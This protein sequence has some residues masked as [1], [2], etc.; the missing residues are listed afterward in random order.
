M[1]SSLYASINSVFESKADLPC[2]RTASTTWT[3]SQ[4]RGLTRCTAGALRQLG[5]QRGDRVLAQGGKCPQSLALY[6][7]CLQLGVIYVPLNPA[8][9]Q[10]EIDYFIND[11]EP[12]LFVSNTAH[13]SSNSHP[14]PVLTVD[15]RGK[16][17][18]TDFVSQATSHEHIEELEASDLAAILYTSGTT[19]KSKGAMLSHGNLVSNAM[20]LIKSWDWQ[21]DDVLLHALPIYHVHGLF[22]A[23]HCALLTGTQIVWH[24]KFEVARVMEDLPKCT[25]MMGVP[26]YYSRLLGDGTFCPEVVSNMRLFISG[27]APLPEQTFMQFQDRTGMRILERYG[28]SETLMNTSNPVDGDRVP[29]TVGFPLPS[30]EVQVVDEEG[31]INPSSEVGNIEVRGPNVFDGYW[32]MPEKS[33]TEFRSNGYFKT[34]DLGFLN[35]EGRLTIVGR[36][37]DVVISG[38]LNIY[39][40]EI[41]SAIDEY[42]GIVETAV[43]GA[44]HPDFGE[45][46]IAVVVTT[47]PVDLRKLR[48]FLSDRLASFKHPKALRKVEELP[49][50]AMGKIQ[51]NSLREQFADTF[52]STDRTSSAN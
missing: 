48:E 36:D 18:L 1:N 49:R 21:P 25:V 38:G 42:D 30:V 9:T 51:K 32:R 50:N 33:E 31:E 22:V 19:G 39:P 43:V 26:T 17:T 28:M 4:V 23:T 27:S 10:R 14:I 47:R 29:G 12:A 6:L 15:D 13:S 45:G 41:E 3:Y 16:G 7:A 35:E 20:A 44:P 34:G 46:L 2:L 5:I 11:T 52:Q 40:A 8:Y 24:E 37:K